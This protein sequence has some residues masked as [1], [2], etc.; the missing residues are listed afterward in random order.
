MIGDNKRIEG[1]MNKKETNDGRDEGINAE[2]KSDGIKKLVGWMES[3]IDLKTGAR[4]KHR[5][6]E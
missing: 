6:E 2:R 5:N 1:T 4:T 3:F